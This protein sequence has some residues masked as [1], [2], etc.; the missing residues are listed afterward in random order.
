MH[1]INPDTAM[2]IIFI[3]LAIVIRIIMWLVPDPK[4]PMEPK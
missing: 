3:I 1:E 4:D 2:A